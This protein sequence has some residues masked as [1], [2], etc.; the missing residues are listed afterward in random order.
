MLQYE[1]TCICIYGIFTE[2]LFDLKAVKRKKYKKSLY[3]IFTNVHIL[4]Y[5]HTYVYINKYMYMIKL[6]KSFFCF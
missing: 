6:K 2:K 1:Y 4:T 3:K 5:R